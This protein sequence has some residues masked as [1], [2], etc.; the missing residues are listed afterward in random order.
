MPDNYHYNHKCMPSVATTH[1]LQ[2]SGTL[3]SVCYHV[4]THIA[5]V[6]SKNDPRYG[7]KLSH[8][9]S[10]GKPHVRTQ[11]VAYICINPKANVPRLA[12]ILVTRRDATL[13]LIYATHPARNTLSFAPPLH[14]VC[15]CSALRAH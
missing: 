7:S 13:E 5:N 9:L 3:H 14:I 12:F 2:Y 10:N 1:N 8:H 15:F 6:M 11:H 4:L